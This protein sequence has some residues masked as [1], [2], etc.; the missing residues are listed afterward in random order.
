[1]DGGHHLADLYS[2]HRQDR[3]PG[4]RQDRHPA[5][6]DA[7]RRRGHRQVHRQDR[8]RGHPRAWGRGT[9]LVL[10]PGHPRF[11]GSCDPSTSDHGR[12]RQEEEG[13][14]VQCAKAEG[15]EGEELDE[16]SWTSVRRP[17]ASY[18]RRT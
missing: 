17:D 16:R 10:H 7:D 3:H 1:M 12:Q 5:R 2:G 4:H 15:Q 18:R 9:R 11:V 13:S 8:H 6:R 14:D